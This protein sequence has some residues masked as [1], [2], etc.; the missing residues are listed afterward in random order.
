[1]RCC[2]RHRCT[3]THPDEQV[4]VQQQD[5]VESNEDMD[6]QSEWCR[7]GLEC[8]DRRC[9]FGHRGPPG[10]YVQPVDY[11]QKAD[12][13]SNEDMDAQSKQFES[14]DGESDDERTSINS[15]VNGQPMSKEG[16]RLVDVDQDENGRSKPMEGDRYRRPRWIPDCRNGSAC[17]ALRRGMNG[18]HGCRFHHDAREVF[19]A[20]RTDGRRKDSAQWKTRDQHEISDDDPDDDEQD[21]VENS[22]GAS[23]SPN[24]DGDDDMYEE[25]A[26]VPEPD[27]E[28]TQVLNQPNEDEEL[29]EEQ[30]TS[31]DSD[32]DGPP[33][34]N[35]DEVWD[36]DQ[37]EQADDQPRVLPD[38]QRTRRA[39][40][41]QCRYGNECHALKQGIGCDFHH[42]AQQVYEAN[43]SD[44]RRKDS[45][46]RQLHRQHEH[47]YD[48][49]NNDQ[50]PVR[51]S[52]AGCVYSV[53]PDEPMAQTNRP[54]NSVCMVRVAISS[55]TASDQM[56]NEETATDGGVAHI[57]ERMRPRLSVDVECS[58]A[59][60]MP[61][62]CAETAGLIET[63]MT[64][65]KDETNDVSNRH[66]PFEGVSSE[67]REMYTDNSST[68]LADEAAMIRQALAASLLDTVKAKT[69]D[70]SNRH[71]G[72]S[73]E[74]REIRSEV[75]TEATVP[76]KRQM[77][78][79]HAECIDQGADH[80]NDDDK[81]AIIADKAP[82]EHEVQSNGKAMAD[83]DLA[84]HTVTTNDTEMF[85][86][87]CFIEWSPT[88]ECTASMQPSVCMN[89]RQSVHVDPFPVCDVPVQLAPAADPNDKTIIRPPPG[90]RTAYTV[91]ETNVASGYGGVSTLHADQCLDDCDQLDI[92]R[93]R[94]NGHRGEQSTDAQ[95]EHMPPDVA[96]TNQ[97]INDGGVR[98]VS[99]VGCRDDNKRRR[100]TC[101]HDRA[102]VRRV[103]DEQEVRPPD[104]AIDDR[105]VHVQM[106]DMSGDRVGKSAD[107]DANEQMPTGKIELTG[108]LLALA[109]LR[110]RIL[111]MYDAS[112]TDMGKTCEASSVSDKI[113]MTV[114]G[115]CSL[116][117]PP[118]RC[119]AEPRSTD[120][121]NLLRRRKDAV[122]LSA[123]VDGR[124]MASNVETSSG[125]N[126]KA[127]PT[128]GQLRK[129]PEPPK[130]PPSSDAADPDTA[131]LAE[132]L[133]ESTLGVTKNRI[134]VMMNEQ[135]VK[136]VPKI[137]MTITSLRGA[138]NILGTNGVFTT[139]VI[140]LRVMMEM[141]EVVK[142][143]PREQ[144]EAHWQR[145]LGYLH[146]AKYQMP[147][148][149][150]QW[151]PDP[152][153]D[154]IRN[155]RERGTEKSDVNIFC[156]DEQNGK[157][158]D[159]LERNQNRPDLVQQVW[160]RELKKLCLARQMPT[161]SAYA[162]N[163]RKRDSSSQTTRTEYDSQM[164][165]MHGGAGAPN[166]AEQPLQQA[167][168]RLQSHS[169]EQVPAVPAVG[170]TGTSI[171]VNADSKCSQLPEQSS[172][173]RVNRSNVGNGDKSTISLESSEGRGYPMQ[174]TV[175]ARDD[176]A[177]PTT[178]LVTNA[179]DLS[180]RHHFESASC[181][182]T[183]RT[184]TDAF[185]AWEHL[186]NEEDV[187]NDM[188]PHTRA[189]QEA[190]RIEHRGYKLGAGDQWFAFIEKGMPSNP[191]VQH[192]HISIRHYSPEHLYKSVQCFNGHDDDEPFDMTVDGMRIPG[193]KITRAHMEMPDGVK[194][195]QCEHVRTQAIGLQHDQGD[196]G[197][198]EMSI[199]GSA[200]T[201][202]GTNRD[203]KPTPECA[204]ERADVSRPK[205][206]RRTYTWNVLEVQDGENAAPTSCNDSGR[207]KV[208]PRPKDYDDAKVKLEL[209]VEVSN[210]SKAFH[211]QT[212]SVKPL[213][214]HVA[215]SVAISPA[216]LA[217]QARLLE[218][219][220]VHRDSGDA[221]ADQQ[222]GSNAKQHTLGDTVQIDQEHSSQPSVVPNGVPSRLE[223][224]ASRENVQRDN[225]KP[226]Q[227]DSVEMHVKYGGVMNRGSSARTKLIPSE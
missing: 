47:S 203:I 16:A 156:R 96:N 126:V 55:D 119:D 80:L 64:V 205:R 202:N 225:A 35:G 132:R 23:A 50:Q 90:N 223:W 218:A 99:N 224:P 200:E 220:T 88:V 65:P 26:Q 74:M 53:G 155:V 48:E 152:G 213:T 41:R 198:T 188:L 201:A 25:D 207:M 206:R 211:G 154:E 147:E 33:V 168:G 86:T 15:D 118:C 94:D 146:E 215:P 179:T 22:D 45:E 212:F 149:P 122:A 17:V 128:S 111:E 221:G 54:V 123:T 151:P 76:T 13:E 165:R 193:R 21:V 182:A 109:E 42:T 18:G 59:S 158:A 58:T 82:G 174:G 139:K 28:D 66:E 24:V 31:I 71:E 160:K 84:N 125:L 196:A 216:E 3:F 210:T 176:F 29:S 40:I 150:R 137:D 124:T 141:H 34:S 2:R 120:V 75:S 87:G 190:R 78:A 189:M 127:A 209:P 79:K 20:S 112:M 169:Q 161:K 170:L 102:V 117:P 148:L 63:R 143:Q 57:S 62:Q 44:G 110:A 97:V 222:R 108:R 9:N 133:P 68:A 37:D 5:D 92:K 89:A 51:V 227:D 159:D 134:K 11:P 69:N 183:R 131:V 219:R 192:L 116:S 114:E 70:E 217:A 140:T 153:D 27:E 136:F 72:A 105:S 81:E 85:S 177:K 93:I 121:T 181:D 100:D 167:D 106:I 19:E 103:D 130:M 38:S 164:L 191:T 194:C 186:L 180:S 197:D 14:Q 73:S 43:R 175:E 166:L 7:W 199:T 129:Q 204:D 52:Y 145:L 95:R 208:G 157:G 187:D 214:A 144:R 36:D 8:R 1:M 32:V 226:V 142:Q 173:Q 56:A 138:L 172:G 98:I 83:L 30:N 113:E 12:V 195:E 49:R 91:V 39:W 163:M 162:L 178:E 115:H 104:A 185:S 171:F 101:D 60:D 4:A 6:A 46:Q 77:C 184:E 61:K 67:M 10:Q 107:V 135:Q